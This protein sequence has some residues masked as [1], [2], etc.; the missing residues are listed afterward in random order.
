MSPFLN[1][2]ANVELFFYCIS[3]Q[4]LGVLSIEEAVPAKFR[5]RFMITKKCTIKP[6]KGLRLLE[7]VRHNVWEEEC[8]DTIESMSKALEQRLRNREV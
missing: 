6:N 4:I 8:Y 7:K 2:Q 1:F 5:S 3:F